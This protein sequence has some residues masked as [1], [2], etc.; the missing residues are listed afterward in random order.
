M[1]NSLVIPE[2]KAMETME[3]I[4]EWSKIFYESGIFEDVK[5]EAQAVVKILAG[6]EYGLS[7]IQSMMNFYIVKNQVTALTKFIAQL[8]K[9]SEHYDYVVEKLDDTEC[10]LSFLKDGKEL[11]KSTFGVKDAAKAGII[12]KDVWKNYPR[13]MFF[14]RALSNGARWY[15]PDI[16]C[17]YSV[18]EMDG[19][20][21]ESK[22]DVVTITAAGEVEKN[23]K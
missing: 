4:R 5:S 15:T 13:N 18:E 19:I 3:S 20:T 6:R 10:I 12:N 11:G 1:E 22:P 8:I 17:G 23:G 7:P 14:N 2:S 9:K 21:T 16:F